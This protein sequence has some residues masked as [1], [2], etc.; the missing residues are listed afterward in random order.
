MFE[1]FFPRP[2]LF[3]ISFAV[4]SIACVVL[5]F[6]VARDAG[7]S[8]S[9][10]G[11]FGFEYPSEPPEFEPLPELS[12]DA[13]EAARAAHA[14]LQAERAAAM[15]AHE[16]ARGSARTFWLYQYMVLAYALSSRSGTGSRRIG[17]R[18]GPSS[19]R[20]RS[21]SSPGSRCSST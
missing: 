3:F 21:S 13:D 20:P 15:A 8:F 12:E 10:G 4:W 9:L 6:S 1:S 14:S 5:W 2:K 16:S 7:E 19:G 18:G 11:W 17:G